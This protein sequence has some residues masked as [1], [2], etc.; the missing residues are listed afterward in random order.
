MI[1]DDIAAATRKRVDNDI[2]RVS[3]NEMKELAANSPDSNF[4]FKKALMGNGISLICEVKKASPSKGVIAEH[5]RAQ[6]VYR[7]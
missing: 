6:T 1:L 3:L 5:F 7:Y 2:S 4:A